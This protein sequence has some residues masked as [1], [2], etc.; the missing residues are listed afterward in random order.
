MGLMLGVTLGIIG[1]LMSLGWMA[2]M[3]SE[4]SHLH[5]R[6]ALTVGG[7][8]VGVALWG[9]IAGAGLP[10]VLRAVRVDPACASGPFVATL[11]DATGMIIY[12][13][14]ATVILHDAISAAPA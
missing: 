11:V 7:G 10:F 2:A 12:L 4:L 13:G 8:I 3:A 5:Q 14:I 9:T 1:M 6:V